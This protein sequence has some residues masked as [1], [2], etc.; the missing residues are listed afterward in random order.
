MK[1]KLLITALLFASAV[2]SFAQDDLNDTRK[3]NESFAK[4]NDKDIR[5]DLASFTFSGIDEGVTA[6]PLSKI[7]ATASG[8]NTMTFRS[9]EITAQVITAPFDKSLH[10]LDFD[11]S[12]L[13]KIDKRTYY[14]GYSKVPK[15]YIKSIIIIIGK[16]TVAIPSSAYSDLFN[17]NFSYVDQTGSKHSANAV[18]VSKDK[19]KI[20]LYLF[21][22]DNTGSYE[23]TFVIQDKKYIRRVLDYGFM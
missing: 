20:Y 7:P 3:K 5:T 8:D 23:V 18:Y 22:K 17:L 11:D 12:T 13:I 6:L 1:I 16:D 15:T 2:N 21:S 19:Q 10:K 14:G 4:V 9:N